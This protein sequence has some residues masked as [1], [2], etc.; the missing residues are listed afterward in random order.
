MG[1]TPVKKLYMGNTLI[2]PDNANRITRITVDF[3][4]IKDTN[5]YAC[6]E[7]ALQRIQAAGVSAS[8]FIKLIAG[9]QYM[10][11]QSDGTYSIATFDGNDAFTFGWNQGPIS[12][13]LRVGSY[14]TIQLQI[15]SHNSNRVYYNGGASS[16][17]RSKKY[18]IEVGPIIDGC[19]LMGASNKGRKKECA[20]M[21][22]WC[23]YLPS[24]QQAGYGTLFH[25][26]H[27]RWDFAEC[28][29]GHS[30]HN[31]SALKFKVGS[32]GTR[33]SATGRS[34][35]GEYAAWLRYPTISFSFQVR[36]TSITTQ[37]VEDDLDSENSE[38]TTEDDLT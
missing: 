7:I 37:R 23:Y 19:W 12:S 26:G 29:N 16:S 6:W 28:K 3:S 31:L 38:T 4:P 25:Q 30:H 22:G 1:E 36:V 24:G 10:V 9:R 11:D 15:P 18:S 17:N 21:S 35:V 2:W 27:C 32:T 14:V 5:T 8:T 20:G 34:S 13:A 33:I